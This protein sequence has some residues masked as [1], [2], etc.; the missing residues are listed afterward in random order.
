MKYLRLFEALNIRSKV[1]IVNQ[2]YQ[3]LEDIEPIVMFLYKQKSSNI[4]FD[5][6]ED[7]DLVDFD[8]YDSVE[9]DSINMSSDNSMRFTFL[10]FENVASYERN[11]PEIH[12]FFASIEELENAQAG[13]EAEKY[14]L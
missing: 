11:E 13:V 2:Y 9:L 7:T 3:F 5:N 6:D 8:M 1:N 12:Y 4:D 10:L 14:N